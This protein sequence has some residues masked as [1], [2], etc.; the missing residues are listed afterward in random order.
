M[1]GQLTKIM[2]TDHED[3]ETET[4][5]EGGDPE[6]SF[7]EEIERKQEQYRQMVQK[8][9]LNTEVIRKSFEVPQILDL[10][11]GKTFLLFS[12]SCID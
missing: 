12:Y 3:G 5:N 7:Q 8:Q 6:E 1:K 2:E 9:R 11:S 10:L 4:E